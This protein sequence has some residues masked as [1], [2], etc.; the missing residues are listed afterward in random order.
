[1]ENFI[2]NKRNKIY[3]E[4]KANGYGDKQNF[5]ITKDGYYYSDMLKKV[6][7]Y[8]HIKHCYEFVQNEKKKN[9]SISYE[10][11]IKPPS[12]EIQCDA[13]AKINDDDDTIS[14]LSELLTQDPSY[15]LHYIIPGQFTMI[16]PSLSKLII[17]FEERSLFEE[18]ITDYKNLQDNLNDLGILY[19]N[20]IVIFKLNPRKISYTPFNAALEN[21]DSKIIKNQRIKSIIDKR[22]RLY[23][24]NKFWI[25]FCNELILN[26]YDVTNINIA[27]FYLQISPNIDIDK[28]EHK[29]SLSDLHPSTTMET[30]KSWTEFITNLPNNELIEYQCP[31]FLLR[32]KPNELLAKMIPEDFILNIDRSYVQ[33]ASNKKDIG[34]TNIPIKVRMQINPILIFGGGSNNY[35]SNILSQEIIINL[36]SMI[37]II[38]KIISH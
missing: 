36:V 24:K 14:I 32:T 2:I 1:M 29:L 20:Q 26:N 10:G 11:L 19:Q 7:I 27:D 17:Q 22:I 4:Q 13:F 30:I 38:F 35:S 12:V 5:T 3:T 37:Q 28:T 34:N 21:F 23:Y 6:N 9:N 33:I 25:W 16:H 15:S 8:Y 31:N 18:K